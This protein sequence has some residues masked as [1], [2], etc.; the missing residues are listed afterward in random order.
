MST[1][2]NELPQEQQEILIIMRREKLTLHRLVISLKDAG[3]DC[4][5]PM[6][7]LHALVDMDFVQFEASPEGGLW[8]LTDR[9]KVA[10]E[11]LWFDQKAGGTD[12]LLRALGKG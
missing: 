8:F 3:V 11:L 7:H 10:A 1:P 5:D 12:K 9:G 2:I 6:P 4:P